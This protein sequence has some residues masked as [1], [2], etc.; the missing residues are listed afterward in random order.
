MVTNFTLRPYQKIAIDASIKKL[1]E[2]KNTMLIAPTGSGKTVMLSSVINELLYI[3]GNK[4]R[5]LVVVH[6]NKINTQNKMAFEKL[7]GRKTSLF[8]SECID[9]SGQ[10]IFGMIQTIKNYIKKIPAF[11]ILVIDE[12]HHSMASTYQDLILSLKKKNPDLYIFGVTATPER[13]DGQNLGKIVD[14]FSCQIALQELIKLGYLVPPVIKEISPF[15]PSKRNLISHLVYYKDTAEILLKELQEAKRNKTVIFVNNL[16]HLNFL[17]DFFLKNKIATSSIHSSMSSGEIHKEQY[18]FEKNDVNILLNID[19][20]T[21]GYDFQP[22]DCVVLM[23]AIGET[24]KGLLMQMVGRGL[25]AVDYQKYPQFFKKDCLILDFGMNIFF[26][27]NIEMEC[28]LEDSKIDCRPALQEINS[29]NKATKPKKQKEVEREEINVSIDVKLLY[30]NDL[31]ESFYYKGLFVRAACGRGKSVY[32]INDQMFFKEQEKDIKKI[33]KQK[34]NIT[35]IIENFYNSDCEY[36]IDLKNQSIEQYQID[37]LIDKFDL[38]GCS[39]YKASTLIAFL[40]N[41]KA[42]LNAM[43]Y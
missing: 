31:L 25:R 41:E 10:V 34:E 42:L 36:L 33:D 14:N 20:A 19:I 13:S 29:K 30:D 39:K 2:R 7:C 17:K 43:S 32:I 22:I 12:F 40:A 3:I 37:L 24:S 11:D 35:E 15:S 18:R 28:L 6:R 4:K 1:L 23:R 16:E 38:V 8:I 27:N 21:E 9:L 26:H 5:V